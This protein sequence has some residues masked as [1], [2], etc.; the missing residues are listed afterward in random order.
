[1]IFARLPSFKILPINVIFSSPNNKF[2]SYSSQVI[3][4]KLPSF[5]HL[6]CCI[7]GKI[8]NLGI[9]PF[10]LCSPVFFSHLPLKIIK[11]LTF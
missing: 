9:D 5:S 1:M 7:F 2:E 6:I 4:N 3:S 11:F 8:N 10:A